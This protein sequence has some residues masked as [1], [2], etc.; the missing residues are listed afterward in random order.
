[1]NPIRPIDCTV[2]LLTP[3][4][5]EQQLTEACGYGDDLSR[6][7]DDVICGSAALVTAMWIHHL[8]PSWLP[9]V[10]AVLIATPKVW[11]ERKLRLRQVRRRFQLGR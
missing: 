9:L 6:W 10:I 7:V 3:E 2:Q 8:P 11:L 4:A 5:F 1:M